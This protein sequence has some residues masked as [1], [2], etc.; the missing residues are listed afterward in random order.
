MR[1]EIPVDSNQT[2]PEQVPTTKRSKRQT[3][4]GASLRRL[5]EATNRSLASS[6]N[7][8]SPRKSQL[9][10]ASIP[11]TE[12][13]PSL[14]A[15]FEARRDLLRS[16]AVYIE[17]P[18][19]LSSVVACLRQIESLCRHSHGQISTVEIQTTPDHPAP[20]KLPS[21]YRLRLKEMDDLVR[22]LY[23]KIEKSRRGAD[24]E[25][26]P[27]SLLMSHVELRHDIDKLSRIARD[28]QRLLMPAPSATPPSPPPE[29]PV[30]QE[31]WSASTVPEEPAES[32]HE[33]YIYE[34]TPPPSNK[35][36]Y[37]RK[38]RSLLATPESIKSSKVDLV[39]ELRGV[40]ARSDKGNR[41]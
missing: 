10:S 20:L 31:Q 30:P 26:P 13:C 4:D 25:H 21:P 27:E 38:T 37:R 34:F 7:G 6:W 3:W 18:S 19:T 2:E 5:A 9:F 35:T 32:R 1:E 11:E 29:A 39:S 33:S 41:A 12:R 23:V 16:L 15:M 40:L 22:A 14:D 24:S 36:P 28:A 17:Q 8:R